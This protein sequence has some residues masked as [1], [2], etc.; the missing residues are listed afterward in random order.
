M[1]GLTQ[2]PAAMTRWFLIAPKLSRLPAQAETMVGVE[3]LTDAV[4]K[5]YNEN[6]QKLKDV[7]KANDPFQEGDHLVNIITKAVMPTDVKEDILKRDKA[8]KDL[9]DKFVKERIVTGSGI[10]I[11]S[12]MKKANLKTW[13][14]AQ[15][16][17]KTKASSTVTALKDDR[18]LF[19]R[20]LVVV[21]SRPDL[22]VNESISNFELAE[23]PRA[24]FTT[25]GNLSHCSAKSKLMN[26]PE[27]LLPQQ[28]PLPSAKDQ[29]RHHVVIIDAMAV[30]QSMGKP[31]WVKMA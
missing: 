17:K 31:T 30:V 24:L 14:S 20:F 23:Y 27:G 12:P 28:Q 26:T 25:D 15:L 29:G 2:Q 6:I 7:I 21:L 13:K 19:A 16:S 4:V 9:F 18:A 22:D 5:R 10:S 11:W 8:G 3:R 1:K